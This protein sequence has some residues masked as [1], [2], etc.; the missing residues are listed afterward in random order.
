M[1][2][3]DI[4]KA[5]KTAEQK[6]GGKFMSWDLGKWITEVD[7]NTSIVSFDVIHEDELDRDGRRTLYKFVDAIEEELLKLG[8]KKVDDEYNDGEIEIPFNAEDLEEAFYNLC[9]G[10]HRAIWHE[11]SDDLDEFSVFVDY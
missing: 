4:I 10:E 8:L 1:G 11:D 3:K 6:S 2:I 7:H 9:Q 5:I